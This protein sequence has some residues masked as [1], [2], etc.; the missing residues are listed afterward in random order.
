M[1]KRHIEECGSVWLWIRV[2]GSALS[3]Y[4]RFGGY[5]AKETIGRA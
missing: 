4:M 2:W 3:K 1:N 5:Q